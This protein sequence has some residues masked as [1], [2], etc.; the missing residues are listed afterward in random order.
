MNHR[1]G[2]RLVDR[3]AGQDLPSLGISLVSAGAGAPCG[4]A[5]SATGVGVGGGSCPRAGQ[6]LVPTIPAR[7]SVIK[8]KLARFDLQ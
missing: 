1:R 5:P 3:A 7:I 4:S 6:L 8:T 2:E